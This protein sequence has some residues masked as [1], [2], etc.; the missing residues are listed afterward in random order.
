VT[1]FAF[2]NGMV[3]PFNQ[4]HKYIQ[5]SVYIADEKIDIYKKFKE[6]DNL[7]EKAVRNVDE[8]VE[9]KEFVRIFGIVRDLCKGVK[10]VINKN[11]DPY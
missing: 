3:G 4:V 8:T 10:N 9:S 1:D 5:G 6:I 7:V 11:H 2:E